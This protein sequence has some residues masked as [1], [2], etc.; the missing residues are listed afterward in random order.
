MK[1]IALLL[2]CALVAC[3]PSQNNV[4]PTPVSAGG[5]EST[6]IVEDVQAPLTLPLRRDVASTVSAPGV[7]RFVT[8][9]V[10]TVGL[11]AGATH[12]ARSSGEPIP[13][14]PRVTGEENFGAI[15]GGCSDD[16][17][18]RID[19]RVEFDARG[20]IATYTFQDLQLDEFRISGTVRARTERRAGDI[21][22]SLAQAQ[23]QPR[24]PSNEDWWIDIDAF[25]PLNADSQAAM[26]R[27]ATEEPAPEEV[28]VP[29]RINYEAHLRDKTYDGSG[30]F[31]IGGFGSFEAETRAEVVDND[32][33]GSEAASGETI[34]RTDSDQLRIV[35]DGA[36]DCAPT[37]T[38]IV[39]RGEERQEL[40]GVQCSAGGR[41]TLWPLLALFV[42]RRRR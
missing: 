15:E 23:P 37:S 30:S 31:T 9:A 5:E 1:S 11:I 19:G 2:A 25:A 12:A 38:V 35:Y 20:D 34:V 29:V 40:A 16:R 32:V 21:Q 13:D 8:A 41:A 7:V 22:S 27:A 17:G 10:A 36:T 6:P 33:C 3:G 42:I 24:P 18:N 14:C 39:E 28:Y 26:R 4:E